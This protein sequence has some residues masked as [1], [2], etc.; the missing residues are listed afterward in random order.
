MRHDVPM[1]I[2][3]QQKAIGQMVAILFIPALP[4]LSVF[5]LML[6]VSTWPTAAGLAIA[7][8]FVGMLVCVSCLKD[9]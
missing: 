4:A 5:M 7:A 2:D 6:G 8:F 1:N 3:E 9:E